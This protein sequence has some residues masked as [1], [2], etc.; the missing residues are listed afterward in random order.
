MLGTD[1]HS[2][3]NGYRISPLGEAVSVASGG[4]RHWSTYIA[5]VEEENR[6]VG[7]C[8]RRMVPQCWVTT[9]LNW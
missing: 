6:L 3:Q 9:W 8:L 1:L 2:A 5:T 4:E 7:D